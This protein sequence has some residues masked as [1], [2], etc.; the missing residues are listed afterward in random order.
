MGEYLAAGQPILVHAPR[1]SYLAWYFLLHE[2]GLVVD[3]HDPAE[4]A[5]AIE[6]VLGDAHLRREISV[7]AQKQAFAD[8]DMATAQES[9]A[10]LMKM[11]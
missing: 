8:F 7:R 11:S 5:S 2:C 1:D 3:S 6:Q 10:G 9:F 4:L